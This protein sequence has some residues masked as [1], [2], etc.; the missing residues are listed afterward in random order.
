MPVLGLG[1][2]VAVAAAGAFVALFSGELRHDCPHASLPALHN[3]KT[4]PPHVTPGGGAGNI[5][6]APGACERLEPYLNS[7]IVGQELALKQ[8]SDAIC[9]HLENPQPARPLVLSLHGPP[10]VGK[11]MFHL[12]AAQA[13]YNKH[14][15]PDLQCPG[16][17]CLG[18]KAS[19]WRGQR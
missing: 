8:I 4:A 12:L 1:W 18:Y 10:G 17:D 15:T 9:D 6:F 16:K 7:K 2:A 19:R 14:I 3:T 13:L 11:S 5:N